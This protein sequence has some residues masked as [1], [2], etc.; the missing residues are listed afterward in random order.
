MK[1]L[2]F[3]TVA[4]TF[5]ISTECLPFNHPDFGRNYKVAGISYHQDPK[6]DDPTPGST[7]YMDRNVA[8]PEKGS[9][10]YR[11]QMFD[12]YAGKILYITYY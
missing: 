4:A 2:L 9:L 7:Y 8:P 12:S 6:V 10:Y 1:V 3:L 11:D 5:M